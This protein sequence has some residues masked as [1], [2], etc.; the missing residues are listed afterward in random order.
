MNSDNGFSERVSTELTRDEL[1]DAAYMYYILDRTEATRWY[2]EW[3]AS[4]DR[5]GHEGW[6][7]KGLRYRGLVRSRIE[8]VYGL[9]PYHSR[10]AVQAYPFVNMGLAPWQELTGECI[11]DLTD[12]IYRAYVGLPVQGGYAFHFGPEREEDEYPEASVDESG[13]MP[14]CF[15][16]EETGGFFFL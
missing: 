6:T 9:T 1:A 12:Q 3:R 10:R 8:Q 16:E 4:L 15:E 2:H 13:S 11:A 7:M 14:D 5:M